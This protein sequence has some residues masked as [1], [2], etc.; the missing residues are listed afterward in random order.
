MPRPSAWGIAGASRKRSRNCWCLTP[1]FGTGERWYRV[2]Q[3]RRITEIKQHRLIEL[4]EILSTSK[5]IRPR[6]QSF[7]GNR[8]WQDQVLQYEHQLGYDAA[9]FHGQFRHPKILNASDSD[10]LHGNPLWE[11][12]KHLKVPR[13]ADELVRAIGHYL[14]GCR[15]L[16][17]IDPYFELSGGT[18]SKWHH[19][20]EAICA[21]AASNISLSTIELHTAG[22]M[23][24]ATDRVRFSE[25]CK[26]YLPPLVPKR[27]TIRTHP[28][29]QR[30]GGIQFHQR[31]ILTDIGGVEIDP[32]LDEGVKSGEFYELRLLEKSELIEFRARFRHPD[33]AYELIAQELVE[34]SG[35]KG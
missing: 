15:E 11:V 10:S 26:H 14:T 17:L 2:G 23:A 34:L 1:A 4:L 24:G 22:P 5:A 25:N 18:R 8:Q 33:G 32:G 9:L 28:W 7:D 29:R 21:L 16:A 27:L 35:T 12:H 13:K 31:W 20:L 30:P 6:D 3:G 19:P